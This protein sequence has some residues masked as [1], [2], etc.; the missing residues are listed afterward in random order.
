MTKYSCNNC[1]VEK[2]IT[3]VKLIYL[4]EKKEWVVEQGKCKCGEY[5]DSKDKT[6]FP[7]LIRTEKSLRKK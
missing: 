2:E 6:G 7:N 5:M 3:R 4:E 1:K